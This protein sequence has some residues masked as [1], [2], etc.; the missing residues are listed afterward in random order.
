MQVP[1]HDA[2]TRVKLSGRRMSPEEIAKVNA[3]TGA[4]LRDPARLAV[5]RAM[6]LD[7][8]PSG[9][10]FD[11]M[12]RL[13]AKLLKAPVALGT[14]IDFDR[15]IVASAYDPDARYAHGQEAGIEYSFCQFTI[16]EGDAF[17]VEDTRAHP[18][19]TESPAVIENGVLAYA[20]IPLVVGGQ[21]LGALCVLDYVPRH[22]TD[23][24][25]DILRDLAAG[26]V[27][28]LELRSALG[29][30]HGR[31]EAESAIKRL[32]AV[33]NVTDAALRDRPVEE[34]FV[35][36]LERIVESL[37]T[38]TAALLLMSDDRRTLVVRA[39]VGMTQ[40]A[41]EITVPVG[42]GIAGR[43]A[44]SGEPLI[45]RDVAKTYVVNPSLRDEVGSVLGVPL[46][47]EGRVYGVIHIGSRASREFDSDDIHLLELVAERAATAI[48]RTRLHQ[49]EREARLA[50]EAGNRAKT[51]FLSVMSHELRTP[52]N[53]IGGYSQ[54]L[55]EGVDGERPIPQKD[56]LRRIIDRQKHLLA[57]IN[58]V[59][60]FADMDAGREEFTIAAVDIGAFLEE[61]K[62]E[63]NGACRRKSLQF[64]LMCSD[65]LMALG[66]RERIGQILDDLVSNAIK[67]T[68]EGGR[69]AVSCSADDHHVRVAVNDSGDGIPADRLPDIFSK[70]V[71]L[72]QS[73][74]RRH[75]G[76]GLGLAMSRALAR[77]MNGDVE[78]EST[79]NEGTTLT[80][81]LPATHG[82]RGGLGR[83]E[84]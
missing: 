40:Y 50:A 82:S 74:T 16:A 42:I 53:A 39:S 60:H 5:L 45:I 32:K 23:E 77:S 4:I 46:F 17:A 29:E 59:L 43:I 52:L 61:R 30:A 9:P 62:E 31:A 68:P 14:L 79:R 18:L 47:V 36:L 3:A 63:I 6:L 19:L 54:L 83:N 81:R 28:E 41:D 84:A 49:R 22:W 64:E 27:A 13:A 34:L 51:E 48:E 37:D 75:E 24:E 76:L 44:A 69:V 55:L 20:G 78:A 72:D 25:I 38:D 66:N 10:V 57:L 2:N 67:F 11:R 56:Y 80:L 70:F 15:Q 35:E 7:G 58:R 33:Q 71:Q 73:T 21:R 65:T 12:T 1:M 26:A 8:V